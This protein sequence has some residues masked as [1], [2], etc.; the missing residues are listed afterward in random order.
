MKDETMIDTDAPEWPDPADEA[1]AIEQA[2]RIRDQAAKGG[3]RFEA[4]LPR[5]SPCGCS[6]G[7]N[8][9]NSSIRPKPCS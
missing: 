7:S 9:E 6:A 2:R 8:R 5:R 3:L 4:Y 1:H